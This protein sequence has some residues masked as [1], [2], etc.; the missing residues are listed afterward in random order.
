MVQRQP[1]YATRDGA[2]AE[3]LPI[4]RQQPSGTMPE[5]WELSMMQAFTPAEQAA[6]PPPIAR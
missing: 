6:R 1:G 3:E 2:L 5:G 4:W